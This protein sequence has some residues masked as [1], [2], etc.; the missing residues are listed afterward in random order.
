MTL[1]ETAQANVPHSKPSL[2]RTAAFEVLAGTARK[3]VPPASLMH[4]G[5]ARG[6]GPADIDLV[7]ELVYGVL[8]WQGS[9]DH[10][11]ESHARRPVAG[12]D[13]ALLIALRI[14]LYQIRYL[15]R[16]P[17][18]AAVDESV[19]L[20]HQ[21]GRRGGSGL[22]NAVLRSICRRPEQPPMPTKEADPLAY[23]TVTL[24]HPE[25][26]AR[27]YLSR[28]DLPEAEALCLRNNRR[29]PTD[30]RVEPPLEVE[31]TQEA[32]S[33]EGISAVPFLF[34]PRC[35]RVTSG[36]PTSSKLYAKGN[37]FIQEAGS[38][39]I[40]F[41]LNAS[42]GDRVLDAC[43]APGA[44]ATEI[45][46]WI[47]P[48]VLFAVDER[49]KRLGL[50]AALA[51]R[52]GSGNL[53]PVAADS[54]FL[55]FR[56]PFSRILL[57]APCSSS[58][59]LARNPDIKWRLREEDLAR[60]AQRQHELLE[61]CAAL[62]APGG[63]LVYATCSSEPEENEAVI[64]RFLSLHKDF[65]VAAPGSTFP[66]AAQRLIRSDGTLRTEPGRDDMDAYFAVALTRAA[67]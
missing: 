9:L 14:G 56:R 30:L 5:P 44:K 13:L 52:I 57:D 22:V 2:A 53:L 64:A 25:W 17:E 7:T 61:A 41:L 34:L 46:P 23:L 67:G 29:P 62:L 66:P 60:H 54:R 6:L 63:R 36:K 26:L 47:R 16:V 55:P 40:P 65:G 35:L 59:T 38:Q 49:P 39:L 50:M 43:A 4:E 24:S 12:I 11:I 33:R 1:D 18:R 48:A 28:L 21:F 31:T 37:I 20:A 51:R 32:L 15:S 10:I 3:G 45:A 42:S 19:K 58:G 8:R 27:R